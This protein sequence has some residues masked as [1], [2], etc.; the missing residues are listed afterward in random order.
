M[1]AG[2]QAQV[3]RNAVARTICSRCGENPDHR[4]DARG[5]QYRWQDYLEI[6]DAA[7]QTVRAYDQLRDLG[8]LANTQVEGGQMRKGLPCPKGTPRCSDTLE[9]F[10]DET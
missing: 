7:I 4:G 9:M 10:P 5:N 8:D 6:A 3:M 2:D 1:T